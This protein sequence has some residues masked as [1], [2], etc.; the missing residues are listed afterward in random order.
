MQKKI[1]K[2][3]IIG[4]G[5]LGMMYGNHIA[6]HD[7]TTHYILD[8]ERYLTYQNQKFVVNNQEIDV[9]LRQ[10]DQ[11]TSYDLVIVAV[12]Y[13]SLQD[14]IDSMQHCVDE[15]TIIISVL[16]GI[17]SEEIISQRYGE[18]HMVY[19]VAQGMDSLRVNHEI[20]YTKMGHL[21]IGK[22]AHQSSDNLNAL[23]EFFDEIEMPY[24]VEEDIL[25]RIW[26]KWMLNIGINQVCM[27]YDTTYGGALT[28]EKASK[29]LLLAMEEVIALSKLEGI[30]L[31]E[32]EKDYY[33]NLM[34]TLNPDSCPSMEQDRIAKRKTE[35][36]MFSGELIRRAKVF[37]LEVPVNKYLYEQIKKI[38]N[39][40]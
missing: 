27:V 34:K 21:C 31:K 7:I 32:E 26:G 17:N 23:I 3:A 9:I 12:K 13:N 37:G 15:H 39:A 4:M 10:D 2:V 36:E 38:E 33:I 18:N 5:A 6:K 19:C 16:N 25:Y 28:K 20:R 24:Q 8:A 1:E 22:L 30:N 11:V 29:T 35:V 40:Y 14:A